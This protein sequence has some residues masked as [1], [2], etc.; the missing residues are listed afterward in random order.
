MGLRDE[1]SGMYNTSGSEWD[2]GF[3]FMATGM[4]PA[5]AAP[6]HIDMFYFGT[7]MTHH[8]AAY[9]SNMLVPSVAK[10]YGRLRLRQEGYVSLAPYQFTQS[11]PLFIQTRALPV[12]PECLQGGATSPIR[13]R[14]NADTG[15]AGHINVTLLDADTGGS[16]PSFSGA[17]VLPVVANHIWVPVQVRGG[18][19]LWAGRWPHEPFPCRLTHPSFLFKSVGFPILVLG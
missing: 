11:A 1:A 17:H 4:I 10:G 19:F 14:I 13:L 8:M 12:A 18:F 3:V 2:S 16:L 6:G 15:V 5:A 9:T 7:Q